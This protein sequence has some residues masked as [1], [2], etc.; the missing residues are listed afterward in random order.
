MTVSQFK[1]NIV[2]EMKK[3]GVND[4][5]FDNPAFATNL[6]QFVGFLSNVPDD[7][8]VS[9]GNGRVSINC[10]NN[11]LVTNCKNY[12]IN[13]SVGSIQNSE[14]NLLIKSERGPFGNSTHLNEYKDVSIKLD[15]NGEITFSESSTSLQ[16]VAGINQNGN[17]DSFVSYNT[18]SSLEMKHY[19]SFGVEDYYMK[20]EMPQENRKREG[21]RSLGEHYYFATYSVRNVFNSSS[22]SFGKYEMLTSVKREMLDTAKLNIENRRKG[23]EICFSATIP[24]IDEYSLRDMRAVTDGYVTYTADKNI[25]IPCLSKEEIDSKIFK[26]QN[27]K[28]REGLRQLSSGREN[29]SYDSS[30]DEKFV[31]EVNG[32]NKGFNK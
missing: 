3:L 10:P 30:L 31:R 9:L 15:G 19:N 24:L 29:Y 7:A 18:D 8:F 6:A 21:F 11:P 23:K 16:N 25:V 12:T 1:D 28:V 32:E 20:M 14:I 4:N 2:E 5:F 13:I 22:P 27:P 17:Y 26:E